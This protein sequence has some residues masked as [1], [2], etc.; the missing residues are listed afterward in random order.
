MSALSQIQLDR[1]VDAVFDKYD[2]NK[3][4]YLETNEIFLMLVDAFKKINR[5]RQVH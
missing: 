5:W 3:N 1:F 4:N 2:I